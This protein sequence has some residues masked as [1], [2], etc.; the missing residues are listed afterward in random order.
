MPLLVVRQDEELLQ[1]AYG[2]KLQEVKRLVEQE[3]VG[4]NSKNECGVSVLHMAIMGSALNVAAYALSRDEVYIDAKDD[5]GRTALHLVCID[6]DS[7]GFALLTARGADVNA[8]TREGKTPLHLA[9]WFD[10]EELVKFL[11]EAGADVYAEDHEGRTVCDDP[12][13]AP[14]IMSIL[15]KHMET[16]AKP[17]AARLVQPKVITASAGTSTDEPQPPSEEGGDRASESARRR[18]AEW[19]TSTRTESFMSEHEG[20]K[21]KAEVSMS[22]MATMAEGLSLGGNMEEVMT[23]VTRSLVGKLSPQE[24]AVAAAPP[25]ASSNP[26]LQQLDPE[27][28]CVRPWELGSQAPVAISESAIDK[29][30]AQMRANSR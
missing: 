12:E 13:I 8:Q 14:E 5:E 16:R 3:D 6:G 27:L 29:M 24:P 21:P 30:L 25:S 28:D 10:Q 15:Q 19:T 18:P 7:E 17:S 11:L 2:G 9:S 20:V 4:I 26:L 23:G 22:A 1:A